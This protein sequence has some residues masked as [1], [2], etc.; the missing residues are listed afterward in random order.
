MYRRHLIGFIRKKFEVIVISFAQFLVTL[1]LIIDV[2]LVMFFS[3]V[4]GLNLDYVNTVT[5]SSVFI[6][7]V[8]KFSFHSSVLVLLFKMF[9]HQIFVRPGR[10][11]IL[12]FLGDLLSNL[13][14]CL[15]NRFL[16][17][18]RARITICCVLFVIVTKLTTAV[19]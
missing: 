10:Q 13:F 17:A 11:H 18:F 6:F 5:F 7:A 15:F 4:P 16:D 3:H 14:K 2:Y 8:F 9:V 19:S 12:C 1:Y